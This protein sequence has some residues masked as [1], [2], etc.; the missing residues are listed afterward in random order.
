MHAIAPSKQIPVPSFD[1]AMAPNGAVRISFTGRA[2]IPDGAAVTIE[3]HDLLVARGD[4]PPLRF[5]A[6]NDRDL[7]RVGAADSIVFR[8]SF[9][10]GGDETTIGYLASPTAQPEAATVQD[11]EAPGLAPR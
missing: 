3:D 5:R 9:P 2:R 11:S 7:R 4:H 6:L 8:R 10:G 1:F